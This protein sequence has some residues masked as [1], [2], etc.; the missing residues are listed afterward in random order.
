MDQIIVLKDGRITEVCLLFIFNGIVY[1]DKWKLVC[2][3]TPSIAL[4]ER[5][6]SLE[7]LSKSNQKKSHGG[8]VYEFLAMLQRSVTKNSN[9]ATDL[10]KHTI[11]KKA[12]V[13]IA[14]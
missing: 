12:Y 14:A 1:G 11:E 10:L 7:H 5:E 3:K 9:Y 4:V 6:R 8:K 13:A 2:H